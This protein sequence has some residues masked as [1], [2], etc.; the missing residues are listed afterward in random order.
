[1]GSSSNEANIINALQ[2][3]QKD[4]KLSIRAAARIYSVPRTTL[5]RRQRNIPSQADTTPKSRKLTNEEESLLI[6]YILDLDSRSQPPRL[7]DV[8]VM[9]NRLLELR[10]GIPVGRN[11]VT[12]F[13]RRHPEVVTRLSRQIDYQRAQCEDP[14]IFEGWFRLVENTIAKYSIQDADIYNFDETGFAMGLITSETVVTGS[15]RR[16]KGRKIQQGNRTWTTVIQCI[17]AVGV[18]L[19]PYI[20]VAAKTHLSSWYENSPLPHNWAISVSEKGWTTNEKGLDWLKH[21]DQHTKTKT[22]GTYRL[23][24]LDGH[25]SHQSVDFELYCKAN[26]IITLCMPAHSSH[27]LQPL[28]VA[29]FRPLKRAYGQAIDDLM[30]ARVTHIT[31][32]EFL[33][34][35]YSAHKA[36]MT[37][38]NTLGGFRGAGIRPF[39]PEHVISQLDVTL[40]TPSPP[41]TSGGL[42]LP[43]LPQTPS[44]PTEALSHTEY[45][46]KRIRSHRSSSPAEII[47][48]LTQMSKC[49]TKAMRQMVLLQDRVKELEAANERLSRRQRTK[50]RRLQSGGSLTL[51][52]G[53]NLA[54]QSQGKAKKRHEEAENSGQQKRDETR[55]RR[56]G[57]CGKTGH[58]SRTCKKMIEI[59]SSEDFK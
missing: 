15:E 29:C 56:C 43:W 53:K 24:I 42:E 39:N 10:H 2:A 40:Q 51:E 3:L 55:R 14:T 27:M 31:K 17:S 34:A 59:N 11:W 5:E 52:A 8:E 18:V 45:I 12:S 30:R 44:N 16:R 46:E 35:F 37:E 33:P 7:R 19:P 23:L 57:N 4:L 21:F 58:N 25:E 32:E 38:K 20:L 9:A 41:G 1:M 47:E 48:S 22:T 36:A 50:K 28:D 49:T 26:C 13:I 6:Q 54:T